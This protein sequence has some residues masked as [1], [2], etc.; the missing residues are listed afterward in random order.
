MDSLTSNEYF[1]QCRDIATEAL[2]TCATDDDVY[3]HIHASID[4]HQWVIYTFYHL[5]ILRISNNEDA[6]FEDGGKLEAD[7]FSNAVQQMAFA[8]FRQDVCEALAELQQER[9]EASKES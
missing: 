3:D 8:A 1:T 5:E 6:F 7:S 9:E 2:D 4:G